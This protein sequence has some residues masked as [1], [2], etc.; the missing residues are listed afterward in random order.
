MQLRI[1][2]PELINKRKQELGNLR[3]RE[4]LKTANYSFFL[5]F[6][7]NSLISHF[8][9]LFFKIFKLSFHTVSF[10]ITPSLVFVHLRLIMVSH[11]IRR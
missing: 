3:A 7:I 1:E 4:F 9:L 8:I 10:S 5:V 6:T 11:D 2:D